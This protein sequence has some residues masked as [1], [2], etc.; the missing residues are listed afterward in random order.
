MPLINCQGLFSFCKSINNR[1]TDQQKNEKNPCFR[2]NKTL[3]LGGGST[4]LAVRSHIFNINY[5]KVWFYSLFCHTACVGQNAQVAPGRNE[6]PCSFIEVPCNFFQVLCSFAQVPGNFASCRLT[7][8]GKA[9]VC[10]AFPYES[11]TKLRN[12]FA[13]SKSAIFRFNISPARAVCRFPKLFPEVLFTRKIVGFTQKIGIFPK[14]V[15]SPCRFCEKNSNFVTKNSAFILFCKG[16]D[17]T[18]IRT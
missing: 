5:V 11:T 14:I 8:K 15:Q 7:K 2:G 6:V 4:L 1:A 12:I 10:P 16:I 3:F 18:D 9:R 17:G 13:K